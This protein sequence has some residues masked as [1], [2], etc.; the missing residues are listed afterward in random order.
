MT[1]STIRTVSTAAPNPGGMVVW[2]GVSARLNSGPDI[3]YRKFDCGASAFSLSHKPD[4]CASSICF[5]LE[6]TSKNVYCS[7]T[8][9]A[10]R[11]Q[12]VT[13]LKQSHRSHQY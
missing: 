4:W 13:K 1:D 7:H 11:L 5:E 12:N 6:N 3:A 10:T 9:T 8:T 2:H